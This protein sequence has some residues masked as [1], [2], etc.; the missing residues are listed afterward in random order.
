M[1]MHYQSQLNSVETNMLLGEPKQPFKFILGIRYIRLDEIFN[2]FSY[3]GLGYDYYNVT[4]RNEMY[5]GQLGGQFR[6]QFGCWELKTFC[7]FGLFANQCQ[8]TTLVTD[9][10]RTVIVRNGG[11][12]GY[13][14]TFAFDSN[15]TLSR[16]I[17]ESW[18]VHLGY[19]LFW[20]HDVVRAPDQLDFSDNAT[21]GNELQSRQDALAHGLN[22]GVESRW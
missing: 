20:L 22:V 15:V 5:G 8:Q 6:Q 2:I 11:N 7:K 19:S 13:L 9:L 3:T 16:K 10:D 18:S 1:E 14:N 17:N 21:S 12:S 4:T